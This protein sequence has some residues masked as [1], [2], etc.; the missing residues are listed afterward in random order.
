VLRQLARWCEDHGTDMAGLRASARR[1]LTTQT[2]RAPER[3]PVLEKGAHN[4]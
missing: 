4:G 3:A 1:R 2:A